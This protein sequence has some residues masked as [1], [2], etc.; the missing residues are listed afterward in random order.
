MK[1]ILQYIEGGIMINKNSDNTYQVFTFPTQ[2]FTINSLLELTPERF[3]ME[4][5]KQE[6]IEEGRRE[7]FREFL[8]GDV[9]F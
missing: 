3:E 4:I 8:K 6:K 9:Q 7:V 1:D 5:E 2:F